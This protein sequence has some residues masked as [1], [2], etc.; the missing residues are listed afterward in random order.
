MQVRVCLLHPLS[1]GIYRKS[2]KSSR[3]CNQQSLEQLKAIKPH[4]TDNRGTKNQIFLKL[5][6]TKLEGCY[7]MYMMLLMQVTKST[8][9]AVY[10][11]LTGEL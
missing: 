1:S 10:A 5:L 7:L 2:E 8:N 4:S 3:T 6:A 9:Q 11:N